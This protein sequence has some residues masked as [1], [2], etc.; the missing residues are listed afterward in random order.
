MIAKNYIRYPEALRFQVEMFSNGYKN[1]PRIMRLMTVIFE[2]KDA[3]PAWVK[4]AAAAAKR[5]V[6]H[7]KKSQIVMNFKA[8]ERGPKERT[9]EDHIGSS[10]WNPKF[11]TEVNDWDDGGDKERLVDMS[12]GRYK[13]YCRIHQHGFQGRPRM[14]RGKYHG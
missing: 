7:W 4:D 11:E 10:R 12:D 6:K 14:T 8:P 3:I 5:L 9:L 1:S 13:S 2:W